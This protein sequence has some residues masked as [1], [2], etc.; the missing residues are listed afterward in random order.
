MRQHCVDVKYKGNNKFAQ[1]RLVEG[2]VKTE[3]DDKDC[4]AAPLARY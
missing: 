3:S 4:Q 2:E 1:F